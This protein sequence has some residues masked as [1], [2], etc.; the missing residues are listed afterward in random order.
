MH[1]RGILTLLLPMRPPHEF[2][3]KLYFENTQMNLELVAQ[4]V[5]LFLILGAGPIVIVLLFARGGNL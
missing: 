1:S 4:L 2:P 3:D 5:S